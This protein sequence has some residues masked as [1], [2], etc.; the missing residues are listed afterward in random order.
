MG[1]MG[2]RYVFVSHRSP[3]MLYEVHVREQ[4]GDNS[5]PRRY[6][7]DEERTGANAQEQQQR[8]RKRLPKESPTVKGTNFEGTGDSAA[9]AT[10][11]F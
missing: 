5:C 9:R 2:Y 8:K 4:L 10:S 3:H 6:I 11:T 7:A 1:Y